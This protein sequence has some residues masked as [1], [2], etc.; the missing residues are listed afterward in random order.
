M[1]KSIGK[2]AE[3]DPENE[4]ISEY[5]ERIH[6]YFEANDIANAKKVSVLLTVIGSKTYSLLRGQ[7]A[8]TLPKD[9]PLK[10]LEKLL[11]DHF[12][13]KPLIIA[14]RFRFYKRAQAAGESL[15]DYLAELRQ[16]AQTCEFGTFLNEALRDKYVVGM[17]SENI[18]KRLLAEDKLTLTKAQEIAQGMEAAAR[19]AKQFKES[20]P[21]V[22]NITS[23]KSTAAKRKPCYRCGR[24]N[25]TANECKFR[26]ATCHNCGKVGHIAPACRSPKKSV[27]SR[28][29][30]MS[31]PQ[32]KWVEVEM[33]PTEQA[34]SDEELALFTIGASASPPIEVKVH[35]NDK[36]VVMELDTGADIS[37]ISEST[38]K[39]MFSTLSLQSFTL[40]L[41]TYTGER[42][43]VLGKLPVRVQYEDQP[44][45]EQTLVVVTGDGPP[46]LGRNWLKSMRL[47]WKKIAAVTLQQDPRKK[48]D[49]LLEEYHEIFSDNLGT[50]QQFKAQLAIKEN[51]KPKFFKPRSVPIAIKPLV[52]GELDRLE[53]NGVL[54][55]V[56]YS[57]WATPLVVVPKKDG[58]V[59]LCGDY[60]VTLNQALDVEQYPLP[61]PDDLFASLA[62]GDKFSVLDLAQAYQQ[63]LLHDE[64]RPYVTINTHRGLYRYTRLPYGIASAPAIFQRVMDTILQGL[65]GV[66]CYIDDILVTGA[67]DT[68]HLKNL[69]AVLKRLQQHGLRLKKSK[70]NFLRPRVEYLGHLIDSQGLRATKSKVEAI[71]N[72]PPPQNVQQLRS[73]LG[74][75]NY[76]RKFIPDLASIIHPL[77]TLL[78]SDCKWNW[79]ETCMQAFNLAKEKLVSSDVL[80]H[81][82][83][84]LPIKVAGDAS[85]YGVGAVLSHVMDDG[86]ERPV[87]FASRT[88]TASE[89]NYAQVEKEALALIFAVKKFHL[90]LYGRQFILVTDHKPLTA[91]LGPQKGT[92]PLAAARLQR[93]AILLSAYHYQIEFRSTTAHANADGLSR[94]PLLK[95]GFEGNSPEPGIFNVSQI[96]SLPVTASQLQTA[97]RT[98]VLLSKVMRYTK[99]GWPNEVSAALLPF[100]RKQQEITVENGCLLWGIRVLVPTK[101]RT[102]LL[103][104]LHQGH[105]G[106]SKMK[107]VSRSYFWWPGLDKDIEELGKSCKS[108]QSVKNSPPTAP[109]YPWSWPSK[110]WERIHVDFAGPFQGSTFLIVVDAYSKWPEVFRMSSTTADKTIEVLRHLFAA[111]GLPEQ[112]VSDNGPQ[113]VSEEF[114]AFM[115]GNGIRHIRTAPYHPSSNGLAER[116]VQSFKQALKASQND[117][118][119]LQHRLS[120]FLLTYRSSPHATTGVPPCT[121]LLKRNLR[122]RFDLL[123]PSCEQ[124]VF[125]KQSLQKSQHDRHAKE[126]DFDIGERVMVRN[127]RPGP[128]WIVGIVKQKSGPH[129]YVVET[130]DKKMWKRHVDHLKALG[131]AAATTSNDGE[132]ETDTYV[133]F[134]TP[135]DNA[136]SAE[137]EDGEAVDSPEQNV[138]E[139]PTAPR[140]PTRNRKA[141]ER[142][143]D[144][145]N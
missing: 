25:H 118:R 9:K 75:L 10:D 57:E 7:L 45:V 135:T 113:F 143:V 125:D 78:H 112:L 69:E 40:P 76:Y 65:P 105:P 26:E 95:P 54:E 117:G 48:L 124:H 19:D 74:L 133:H 4:K 23:P 46:L 6:L 91:I 92:P 21:V 2:I 139:A 145:L 33:E 131:D 13:P 84:R 114:A 17:R 93:W 104:E 119:S 60:K 35:I 115:R 96:A 109:L 55:R 37:I 144:E 126:R 47:N 86:S 53:Q 98:D 43:S 110:P 79:S 73:F 44:P 64:S 82:D 88:L 132:L 5:L 102:K 130:E 34:S 68:E 24:N 62:G 67:N 103:D 100:Q 12:E 31:K 116:F 39:S 27:K 107:A 142:L 137:S 123:N 85:A 128:K 18:Q 58:R 101:L 3:F 32:T 38:Y 80:V 99:H 41:K 8:P 28:R 121:L 36:P 14:E 141:P 108:C 134:P 49:T 90:Y 138:N 63:L 16:L 71:E 97:T 11:K 106:I 136:E 77:T 120:T 94:L 20:P 50:I 66:M 127:L 87:A 61:Q 140:Y 15:A 52:E 129:S 51:V 89:R 122:T 22:M 1:A 30:P 29:T 72:A 70:C 59:R 81:Y 111:Q 42:M 56:T 83:P